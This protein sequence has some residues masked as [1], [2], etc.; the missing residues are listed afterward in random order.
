MFSRMIQ[1]FAI[2]G[3]KWFAQYV[4]DRASVPSYLLLFIDMQSG[5]TIN[6]FIWPAVYRT[7]S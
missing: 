1:T 3:E 7:T 5:I 4:K 6:E 2:N